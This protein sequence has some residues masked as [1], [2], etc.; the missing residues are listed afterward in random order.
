M[1]ADEQLTDQVSR[2]ANEVEALRESVDELKTALE[3]ALR[4]ARITVQFDE[5]ANAPPDRVAELEA[6]PTIELFEIGDGVTFQSD[7]VDHFGEIIALDDGENIAKVQLISSGETVDVNQDHLTRLE[8]D[9]LSY[10]IS[11][12]VRETSPPE[13]VKPPVPKRGRQLTLDFESQTTCEMIEPFAAAENADESV[14]SKE[15]LKC[16]T[17][18]IWNAVNGWLIDYTPAIGFDAFALGVFEKVELETS[19]TFADTDQVRLLKDD[20]ALACGMAI[21]AEDAALAMEEQ[22]LDDDAET[23]LRVYYLVIALAATGFDLE[24][25]LPGFPV[26]S[27]QIS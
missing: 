12:T 6:D 13:E 19:G 17:R 9:P 25:Y 3:W 27:L 5:A 14:L 11:K 4:N 8:N 16:R 20:Y 24:Y 26:H 7:G 15:A 21:A 2:L 18:K 23:V 10:R 22:G 1:Q